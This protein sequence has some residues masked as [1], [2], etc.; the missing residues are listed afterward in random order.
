MSELVQVDA[1][2]IGGGIIGLF[3]ALKLKQ[4]HPDWEVLLVEKEMYLGDHSTGRN[5]GV[6]HSGLYYDTGSLKHQLCLKGLR[7]WNEL[8]NIPKKNCGKL[9]F[10]SSTEEIVELEKLKLQAKNN[11]V[12]F[13]ELSA[14]QKSEFESLVYIKEGIFIPSTGILDV[15][16]ALKKLSQRFEELGGIIQLQTSV[17]KVQRETQGFLIETPNFNVQTN[18]LINCAGLWAPTIRKQLGLYD[19]ESVYV[20]GHYLRSSQKIDYQTLLYPTPLKDLKGLGVHS[21]IDMDG[22]VK[23]GPDT[24]DVSEINYRME[25]ETLEAMKKQIGKRF[26]NIDLDR[27]GPD[28]CGIRSK[29]NHN[30]SLHKDFWIKGSVELGI[31][32]YAEACGI[33]SPGV[34]SAPEIAKRLRDLV[35]V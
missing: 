20:K 31:P 18:R 32:G 8:E 30:G 25:I 5:S 22:N 33:E 2:I 24:V 3:T 15:S 29:I 13:E 16:V 1:T 6:L 9:I 21:T 11:D 14:T 28:Y 27:L 35:Y 4:K 12:I 7:E 10:A 34:T 17:D 23:F 19:I 26:K